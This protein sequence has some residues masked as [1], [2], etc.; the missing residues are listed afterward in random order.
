MNLRQLQYFL[1][2]S[3]E[4]NYHKAAER[5]FI[6]QPSL[7]I[8]I[9]NLQTELDTKLFLKVGRHIELTKAGTSLAT[10][11]KK[12]F[13][14]SKSGV[15]KLRQTLKLPSLYWC[16]AVVHSFSR[17]DDIFPTS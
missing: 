13:E 1:V 8:Q 16:A 12:L 3:E 14:I 9:K 10:S 4:L 17:A 5:L 15:G 2:L 11:A 6:S 7:S